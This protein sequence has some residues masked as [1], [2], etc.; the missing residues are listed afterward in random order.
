MH[1]ARDSFAIIKSMKKISMLFVL[2]FAVSCA[3]K[4]N[5][6]MSACGESCAKCSEKKKCASCKDKGTKK[7]DNCEKADKK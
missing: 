5:S 7:C 6:S 4:S 1:F 3:H 2:A